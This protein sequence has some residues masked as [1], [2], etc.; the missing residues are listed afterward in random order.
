MTIIAIEGA[1]ITVC[2]DSKGT[3]QMGCNREG[4]YITIA[5]LTSEQCDKLASAFIKEVNRQ[6]AEARENWRMKDFWE[7]TR[8][9]EVG[10]AAA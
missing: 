7:A 5:G 2:G 6:Q 4:M 9:D 10:S 3:T 8:A 1:S